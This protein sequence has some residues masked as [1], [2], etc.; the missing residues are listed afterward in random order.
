MVMTM[1]DR[2]AA[3][4]NSPDRPVACVR[5]MNDTMPDKEA[6]ELPDGWK[7]DNEWVV[8]M[9]RGVDDEGTSLQVS[10]TSISQVLDDLIYLVTSGQ[11]DST[12]T[13]HG[14]RIV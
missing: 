5:Q 11:L 6:I 1:H 9:N 4:L 8:D 14:Y 10:L 13:K 7:W 3:L 2:G 12:L